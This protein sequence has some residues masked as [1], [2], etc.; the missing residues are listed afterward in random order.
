MGHN[1][2]AS[3][4]IGVYHLAWRLDPTDEAPNGRGSET[5]CTRTP[6]GSSTRGNPENQIIFLSG[7][8]R[9]DVAVWSDA[10][11]GTAFGACDRDGVGPELQRTPGDLLAV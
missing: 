8:E 7:F 11:R 9:F 5:T 10:V 4:V 3:V 1:L 2:C 6:A